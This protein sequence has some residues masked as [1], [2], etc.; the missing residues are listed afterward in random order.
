MHSAA[1][2]DRVE[3]CLQ[4]I[5]RIV[6]R[7]EQVIGIAT[8]QRTGGALNINFRSR[9]SARCLAAITIHKMP[10]TGIGAQSIVFTSRDVIRDNKIVCRNIVKR[11]R[12]WDWKNSNLSMK[13]GRMTVGKPISR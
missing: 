13:L 5:L 10:L 9:T 12:R 11:A 3:D 6:L 1:V 2:L 8:P 7:T 4:L